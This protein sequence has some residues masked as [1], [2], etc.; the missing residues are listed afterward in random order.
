VQEG[1]NVYEWPYVRL[2]DGTEG[3]LK[4]K[5]VKGKYRELVIE[6]Q[7]RPLYLMY[8]RKNEKLSMNTIL[9]WLRVKYGAEVLNNGS[10]LISYT[11]KLVKLKRNNDS[12]EGY[13]LFLKARRRAYYSLYLVSNNYRRK[14]IG[15]VHLKKMKELTNE[16]TLSKL[17]RALQNTGYIAIQ[18]KDRQVRRGRPKK[19]MW[20]LWP[21]R[22]HC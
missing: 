10:Q 13:P 3:W 11:D 16:F 19:R 8:L 22:K 2:R 6:K 14:F 9:N 5:K 12:C 18:I 21:L 7:G 15:R 20:K 1:F 4:F 17:N